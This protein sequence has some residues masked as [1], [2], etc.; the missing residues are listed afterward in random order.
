MPVSDLLG[1]AYPGTIQTFGMP[2]WAK[3]EVYEIKA[4]APAMRQKGD[5]RPM[6][7]HLLEDRFGLRVHNERRT[8]P[9]FVLTKNRRDG[10]LGPNLK[11]VQRPCAADA[12]RSE[13]CAMVMN[14]GEFD[15]TGWQWPAIVDLLRG[16]AGRPIVDRTSLSGQFDVSLRWNE[17]GA[18]LPD[19]WEAPADLQSRATFFTAVKEQLGLKLDPGNAPM[20]VLVIDNV[21]RPTP[22]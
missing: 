22:N 16:R 8:I 18:R 17:E 21:E 9:V 2:E 3:T 10:K 13:R 4:T 20:E 19:G 14:I 1:L 15:A 7:R 5:L 11:A 12:K 6:V